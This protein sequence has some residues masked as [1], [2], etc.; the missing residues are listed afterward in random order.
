MTVK[1]TKETTYFL[2]NENLED[3]ARHEGVEVEELVGMIDRGE[4]DV[5]D[6]YVYCGHHD[7]NIIDYKVEY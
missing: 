4:V 3:F 5:Y 7:C 2:S 6:I 1:V